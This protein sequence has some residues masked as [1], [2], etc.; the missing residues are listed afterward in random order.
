MLAALGVSPA[1]R[2]AAVEV[3]GKLLVA[4]DA[5]DFE[6]GAAAWPQR[7]QTGIPGDFLPSGSPTRQTVAGA[8]AIVFD[9]DGDSFAGPETTAA[10]HARG[11]PHSVEIWAFQGNVHDQES[12]VSWGKRW[13]PDRTF[14]GFRYGADPDF[15][16]IARWGSAESGFTTVP[17]PGVWHLLSYSYDGDVQAVYVDGKPDNSRPVGELDAHDLLP[18]LVGVEMGG[19]VKPDDGFTEFS[20]A[21]GRLR[22]Q[23]GALTAAQIRKNFEAERAEFPGL[24][25]EKLKQA[26]MHRFSFDGPDGPAPDGTGIAD[27]IGGLTATVRGNGA[28]FD[29]GA[30]RLPGGSS[31]TAAY[32]DFPNSLVSSSEEVTIEF[33]ESQLG[34]EAWSRI[35]S[36]GTNSAG[37]IAGPGG[38]FTGTETLTLF[39][40]V[41][42]TRVNRFARSSGVQPN[43]GPD[44]NPA[45]Y[46]ESDYGKEFQQTIT[47]SKSLAEWH[48]YRNGVL[49]EVIPDLAGPSAIDDVNVWLGRSEFSADNNFRG[50]FREVRIYHRALSEGEIY[51]NFLAGPQ[52]LNLAN[53][54]VAMHWLPVEPGEFS[55][56]KPDLWGGAPPNG[57]GSIA[58][59]ASDIRGDQEIRI[60]TPVILGALNL[61]SSGK[62]GSFTLRAAAG[63]TITMDSGGP[64]P[65]SVTQLPG[66]PENFLE[67]PLVL[68]SATDFVNSSDRPLL[69]GGGISGPGA[70]EKSGSGAVILTGGGSRHSGP[71]R[72]SAGELILGDDVDGGSLAGS[73][74]Q[75]D[76]PGRLVFNRG[77]A[78]TI[79]GS[80]AGSGGISHTG[81][82]PLTLSADGKLTT[83]G[84]LEIASRSGR[85]VSEGVIDG[86]LVL[87]AD[88]T[89]ELRGKSRTLIRKY[90]SIGLVHGGSLAVRDSAEV[91]ISG[92]GHL[93]IGDTGSGVSRFDISGGTVACNEL[94][95]GKGSGT[96][97]VLIQTGGKITKTSQFDT[98]LAG[99]TLEDGDTWA[100][101]LMTGGT[102]DDSWNLQV[103]AHGSAVMEV[104]GGE[105]RVAGFL[106]IGR[107]AAE[108]NRPSH[109]LLDVKSGLVSTTATDTLLLVGE[110]GVGVL[111]IREAGRVVCANRMKIGAGSPD[112]PGDGT[113]NLLPGGVLVTSGIGQFNPQGA[114]GRLNFD[115]GTLRAGASGEDFIENLDFI[116]VRK[117]GA[118]IDTAGFD[119]TI[120]PPLLAP[121]GDGLVKI[122]VLDGGENFDG[123]PFVAISGGRGDGAAALAEMSGGSVK[124]IFIA[125][126]GDGYL[127]APVVTAMGGRGTGLRLGPARLAANAS[128]G[129]TK[130]GDGWLT[131]AGENSYLGTTRVTG[132]GLQVTGSLAGPVSVETGARLRGSGS[133]AGDVAIAAG[134]ELVLDDKPLSIDGSL[135]L[136]GVLSAD[137]SNTAPGCV[138]VA[139]GLDLSS[140]TL[141]V[142][143][144]ARPDSSH[145]ILAEY[146]SLAGEFPAGT[147]L[148]DGFALDYHFLGRNRIALVAMPASADGK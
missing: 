128:G 29:G 89:V 95:L 118:F 104:A 33:W 18:I 103:G 108:G 112:S 132:G 122:P 57:P 83:T 42:A 69:I 147:E 82:G 125:S 78:W 98:R 117:R 127:A 79:H 93:N 58:T 101:W 96:A 115:G 4:L 135:A 106:S 139:G 1:A 144:P 64:L 134:G 66:S 43:G 23:S 146:G 119:V 21:L 142:K 72:V 129:L 111:N 136:G 73:E 131:L 17:Q 12:I 14:A 75:I 20:G 59:I 48:W 51:G 56:E 91:N 110:E 74:F 44:R 28:E 76:K 67:V 81:G 126:P 148:P 36:I 114:V 124:S 62:G 105:A 22:I 100:F 25:A 60:S 99:N 24:A 45:D 94:F 143:P 123:P 15:G 35:L 40:N 8:P 53:Q 120:Q 11:A 145:I 16:A 5:R 55:F 84:P 50:L 10:L 63:G 34:P 27:A 31:N 107:F 140:A 77:D 137:C 37:E 9:G 68:G 109:G 90:L 3:A 92:D 54:N 32:L 138:S 85:F 97:G 47:W 46:P 116:R 52:R 7:G 49:M 61:G 13:G 19:N 41:G 102:F 121:E 113:V 26:P 133:I 86:P 6:T 65:S 30:I 38:N 39:G 88:S 141:V 80:H 87:R 71:V 130:S 2:V 70:F